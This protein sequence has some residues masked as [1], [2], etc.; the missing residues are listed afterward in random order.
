MMPFAVSCYRI[1]TI[2]LQQ[3]GL[4]FCESQAKILG[5]KLYLFALFPT[6]VGS[7]VRVL[8]QCCFCWSAVLLVARRSVGCR[9]HVARRL[10][11]VAPAHCV[12]HRSVDCRTLPVCQNRVAD[13]LPALMGNTAYL[14][15]VDGN[16]GFKKKYTCDDYIDNCF[17]IY[18]FISNKASQDVF[19][20][21]EVI[22]FGEYFIA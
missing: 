8:T 2:I 4:D 9:P 15:C 5:L 12:A 16:P 22:T 19:L 17:D 18:I 1:I 3:K 20:C 6:R 21:E 10:S 7:V 13:Q 14:L 11:L